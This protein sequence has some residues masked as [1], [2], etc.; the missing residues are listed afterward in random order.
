MNKIHISYNYFEVFNI[1][2]E[3][4]GCCI[5]NAITK[6]ISICFFGNGESQNNKI[7]NSLIQ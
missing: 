3:I 5:C 6:E 7:Q 2:I 4:K 1:N